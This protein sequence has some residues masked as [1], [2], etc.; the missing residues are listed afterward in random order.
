M[1]VR[2]SEA[3][4]EGNLKEGKGKMK[5]GA[6]AYEGPFSFAS[7]FE[8]GSGTNPE[9]LIAAALAGC[10]SMALSAGL[11][12][13]GFNPTRVKTV[14]KAHLEKVGEGFKITRMELNS[15]AEI[16]G[17]D[18]AKFNEIAEATKKGCPVSQALAGTEIT[19]NA[20]LL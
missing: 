17:I 7:R 19:L 8:S 5:V 3:T 2:T 14:A 12:K 11:G 13:N 4:W 15:E 10:F 16:P 18:K 9:E 6:G 20:K 1:A